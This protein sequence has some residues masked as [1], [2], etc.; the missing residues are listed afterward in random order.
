MGAGPNDATGGA[1]DNSAQVVGMAD[2]KGGGAGTSKRSASAAEKGACKGTISF[3]R[4]TALRSS[5]GK[6]KKGYSGKLLKVYHKAR[7]VGE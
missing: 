3:P 7:T 2:G 4:D 5:P 6:F 1:V